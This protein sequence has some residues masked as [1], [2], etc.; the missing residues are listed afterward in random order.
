MTRGPLAPTGATVRRPRRLLARAA[1][2]EMVRAT[3]G[4]LALRVVSLGLVFAC[5]LLLTRTLGAHGYGLYAYA[6]AWLNA[7]IVPATL[8]SERLVVRQVAVYRATADWPSWRGVLEWAGRSVLGA[9]L[10][11]A[12]LAAAGAWLVAG[13]AGAPL[14][15]WTAMALLPVL[16]L[17]R[18]AQY[19]LQGMRLPVLGQFAEGILHPLVF[20]ALLVAARVADRSLSAA[21]AMGLNVAATCAALACSL[22]LLRRVVPR[23]VRE[24]TPGRRVDAWSRSVLPL[25]VAGGLYAVSGQVPILVLGALGGTE[26]A[27]VLSV[28]KRLSDLLLFPTIAAGATLAPTLAGLWATRDTSG[29]QRTLTTFTRGVAGVAVPLALVLLLLRR[30]LL[31]AFG[32]PFGAGAGALVI[33]CVGQVV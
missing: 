21:G 10:A 20:V 5:Q 14:V 3:A 33:L 7:L 24:A 8:G 28:A 17:V 13:R 32:A 4:T 25:V 12:L 6:L 23:P 18:L 31:E 27:G 29:F 30:P 9:A 11:L 15:F 22:E 16:A 19:A 26:A 1:G 2:S